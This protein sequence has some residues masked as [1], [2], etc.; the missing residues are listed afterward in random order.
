MAEVWTA[1]MLGPGGFERNLVIKRI[2][3][4]LADAPDF[5][6]MFVNEAR[7]SALLDHPNIV[8]VFEFGDVDGQYFLAMEYVRGKDLAHILGA[9]RGLGPLPYGMAALIGRDICRALAYAH[10]LTAD[11]GAPLHL[12]HRDISPTNIMVSYEG[13][14]MLLDFGIAKAT[15]EVAITKAGTIKGKLRYMS[16]EQ[17]EGAEIDHRSDIFSLG[18]TLHEM[19]T[20]RPLFKG[21]NDAQTVAMICG[22]RPKPP[23]HFNSA[24]PPPLDEICMR[25]LARDR[26]DRFANCRDMALALDEVV[27]DTKWGPERLAASMSELFP[28][29]LN[30]PPSGPIVLPPSALVALP[31]LARPSGEAYLGEARAQP[32][33]RLD[34]SARPPLPRQTRR[35]VGAAVATLSIGAV[36]ALTAQLS[37]TPRGEATRAATAEL[38]P[39]SLI[40]VRSIPPGAQV[41]VGDEDAPRGTTPLNLTLARSRSVS[42]LTLKLGEHETRTLE[43]IPDRDSQV[44]VSLVALP[45]PAAPA[46]AG[47][48]ATKSSEAG[49]A[50]A[51]ERAAPS[52][53]AAERNAP[54]HAA[55]RNAPSHAA[56]RN[57]P[58]RT[59]APDRTA[60]VRATAPK[61]LVDKRPLMIKPEPTK[62]PD[63]I[64]GQMLN[65]FQTN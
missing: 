20:G 27:H 13:A 37:R 33:T 17:V 53:A 26:Q 14:V 3:A 54:S 19:L 44:H 49:R 35:L 42:K 23:S 61:R 45:P 41:F 50:A 63:L 25:A 39:L 32:A 5:V 4:H 30:V 29:S 9:H 8:R 52:R 48:P 28:A 43:V 58:A 16:P 34:S 7:L 57:L 60:P 22:Q 6:T 36:V 31:A 40:E 55:E 12:V 38:A 1:K 47:K 11:T 2:L 21:A 10:S 46:P 56:E 62:K 64:H 24:V 51:A 59:T 15:A 18:A 65:P